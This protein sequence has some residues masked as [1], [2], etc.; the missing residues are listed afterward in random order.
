[1]DNVNK[2]QAFASFD[3]VNDA[4]GNP[5]MVASGD[6]MTLLDY[7]AAKVM[8][9]EIRTYENGLSEKYMDEV[10]ETSYMQAAAMLEARKKYID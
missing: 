1:M 9:S 4:M 6:G 10:A 8:Q 2:I 3:N 5:V 7:F